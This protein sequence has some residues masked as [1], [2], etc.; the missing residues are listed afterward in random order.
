MSFRTLRKRFKNWLIYILV[1]FFVNFLRSIS[2]AQALKVMTGLGWIGYHVA[3]K[4]RLKAIRHLTF[5]FGEEKSKAEIK[6]MAKEVFINIGRNA[7]DAIR[8][9]IVLRDGI[10]EI[11]GCKANSQRY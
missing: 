10:D 5:V 4:E 1:R 2:R 8:L 11:K 7:T 9:P 3:A 6:A